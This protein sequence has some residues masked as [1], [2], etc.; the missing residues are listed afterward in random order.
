ML[1][2]LQV[3]HLIDQ[4]FLVKWRFAL[5]IK[6]DMAA[7]KSGCVHNWKSYRHKNGEGTSN[8]WNWCPLNPCPFLKKNLEKKHILAKYWFPLLFIF[9]CQD[10]NQ[11]FC[12]IAKSVLLAFLVVLTSG[13]T[14]NFMWEDSQVISIQIS[15]DFRGFDGVGEEMAYSESV[16]ISCVLFLICSYS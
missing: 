15:W 12:N 3:Y 1:T 7:Y 5:Q 9:S 11:M 4:K 10:Q 16:Q 6:E 2:L 14:G 8:S 13:T